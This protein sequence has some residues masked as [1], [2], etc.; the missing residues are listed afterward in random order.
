MVR[1]KPGERIIL[2]EQKVNM[3]YISQQDFVYE[4]YPSQCREYGG[5]LTLTNLRLIF[6]DRNGVMFREIWLSW[7]KNVWTREKGIW[8]W[9]K[10]VLEIRW[11]PRDWQSATFYVK[12]G[13][14]WESKL[15]Y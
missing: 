10:K 11:G 1:L 9:K 5:A 4:D 15:K 8:K 2:Q 7:L 14:E 6:E 13:D 3:D 12:K